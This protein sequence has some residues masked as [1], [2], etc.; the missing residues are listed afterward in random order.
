M[1]RM[2]SSRPQLLGQMSTAMR[3]AKRSGAPV[4]I[5][6]LTASL[7]TCG[8]AAETVTSVYHPA[9]DSARSRLWLTT[10]ARLAM[11]EPVATTVTGLVAGLAVVIMAATALTPTGEHAPAPAPAPAEPVPS[12]LPVTAAQAPDGGQLRVDEQGFSLAASVRAPQAF[13]GFVL[14][15]TS[16]D[17]IAFAATVTVR[18]LDSAG[19]PV[20]QDSRQ[21]EMRYTLYAVFPG[22]RV[23][24]GAD[25]WLDRRDV[26]RLEVMVGASTWVP[27]DQLL[28]RDPFR[29]TVVRLASLTATSVHT[30]L[31]TYGAQLSFTANSG[32]DEQMHAGVRAIFRNSAGQIV[33]GAAS[34]GVQR[35][36]VV[37]PG[38]SWQELVEIRDVPDGVD[39]SRTEV[40]LDAFAVN[41]PYG[42]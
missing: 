28:Q 41:L 25:E 13:Y 39:T 35:C 18:L 16:R 31:R 33:G 19:T 15:N 30:V 21:P 14:E 24:F 26:A 6:F 12:V 36:V 37:T 20:L 4:S 2:M 7:V 9:V 32:Y 8:G 1:V 11:R 34:D 3:E 38:G 5:D 42:C 22:Q 40:Y 29:H 23:T 17:R 27:V 10:V